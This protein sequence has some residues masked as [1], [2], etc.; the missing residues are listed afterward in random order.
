MACQKSTSK[1]RDGFCFLKIKTISRLNMKCQYQNQ[2]QDYCQYSWIFQNSWHFPSIMT[3]LLLKRYSFYNG[4]L[5]LIFG[6]LLFNIN[7]Q[8][9]DFKIVFSISNSS[10]VSHKMFDNIK[11]QDS[12]L[13]LDQSRFEFNIKS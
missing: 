12:T 5:D 8:H 13:K 4:N 7:I 6:Y 2:N 9:Q 10:S 11:I 1:S 3:S